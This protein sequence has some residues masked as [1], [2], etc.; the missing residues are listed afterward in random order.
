MIPNSLHVL[1]IF[2]LGMAILTA[3]G[4]FLTIFC[5]SFAI[6]CVVGCVCA[7]LT[8]FTKVAEYPLLETSLVVLMSYR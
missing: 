4:S 5:G 7:F 8:K 3:I 2:F 1:H 6:G